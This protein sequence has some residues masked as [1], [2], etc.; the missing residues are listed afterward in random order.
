MR[1]EERQPYWQPISHPQI[2]PGGQ[3]YTG[4]GCDGCTG[5][6]P[7][8]HRLSLNLPLL[9]WAS[10]ETGDPKYRD[11]AEKHIHTSGR[12]DPCGSF[13]LAHLFLR[14]EDGAPDHGATC[15][16]TA[17]VRRGREAR[18]GASTDGARLQVHGKGKNTFRSSVDVT[19]FFLAHLPKDMVPFWDLSSRTGTISREI[20]PRRR[21]QHAECLRWQNI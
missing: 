13:H 18:H 16:D 5:K 19:D 12:H 4:V 15:Q 11:I 1:R 17:T 7:A 9:Y 21:S 3:F 10:E 2:S 14:Y 20:P 6:L 8:D